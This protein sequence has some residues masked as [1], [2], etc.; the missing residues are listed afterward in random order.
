LD[1]L[2]GEFF[3]GAGHGAKMEQFRYTVQSR[4][5]RL[6]AI[7][8]QGLVAFSIKRVRKVLEFKGLE[9]KPIWSVEGCA[10]YVVNGKAI[11]SMGGVIMYLYDDDWFFDIP[12]LPWEVGEPTS[13]CV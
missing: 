5:A 11:R 10:E 2:L 13:P 8:H 4:K 6:S 1:P 3:I 12:V 7:R 9:D